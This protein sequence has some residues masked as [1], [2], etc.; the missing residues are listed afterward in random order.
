MQYI[1]LSKKMQHKILLNALN[2]SSNNIPERFGN[3]NDYININY[4]Y[5]NIQEKMVA[6]ILQN[7]I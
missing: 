6:K 3:I 1:L 7:K 2:E 5:F 4:D